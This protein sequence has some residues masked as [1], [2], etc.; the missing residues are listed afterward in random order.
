M[1]PDNGSAY[2]A[3]LLGRTDKAVKV[4]V[5]RLGL[6]S[7]RYYWTN[8]EEQFIRDNSGKGWAWCSDILDKSEAAIQNKAAKMGIISGYWNFWTQDEKTT[9]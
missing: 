3:R 1:Y 2:Y 7:D 4:K 5:S 9:L 8:E 6:K